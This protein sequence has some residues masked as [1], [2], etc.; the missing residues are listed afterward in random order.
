M[1]CVIKAWEA[2]E[3]NKNKLWLGRGWQWWTSVFKLVVVRFSFT[4][5]ILISVRTGSDDN[6][7]L[8]KH[9]YR[10]SSLHWSDMENRVDWE[11]DVLYDGKRKQSY[12]KVLFT[13]ICSFLG[14]WKY[15]LRSWTCKGLEN[16][17]TR[18]LTP[19]SCSGFPGSS[20]GRESA[21]S[22]GD[23]GSILGSG[24]SPGAGSGNPL[25]Y[26]CLENSM[27]RGVWWATVDRVTKSRTRMSDYHHY[28]FMFR[29]A[30][31]NGARDGKNEG[32]FWRIWPKCW[33]ACFRSSKGCIEK[34]SFDLRFR[35][36]SLTHLKSY[37]DLVCKY[38]QTL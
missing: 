17:A 27:D 11:D 6:H 37:L 34:H 1:H 31:G 28:Y 10:C 22:A 8:W 23:P 26:S 32:N 19:V 24:R 2:N 4:K 29:T 3:R 20:E 21:W 5:S 15:F 16:K 7:N 12:Q 36:W 25:K 33:F 35:I 30:L 18:Y 14:K 13:N 38:R 9:K